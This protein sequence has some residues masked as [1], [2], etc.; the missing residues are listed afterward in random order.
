MVELVAESAALDDVLYHTDRAMANGSLDLTT[1]LRV[2]MS[3]YVM[4]VA[5]LETLSF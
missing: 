1:F 2:C 5:L 3:G 4:I